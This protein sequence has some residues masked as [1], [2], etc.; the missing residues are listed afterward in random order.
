MHS[1]HCFSFLFT[2]HLF[3]DFVNE[4][5]RAKNTSDRKENSFLSFQLN[6]IHLNN[7]MVATIALQHGLCVECDH[8]I[9]LDQ[10]QCFSTYRLSSKAIRESN[11]FREEG[12]KRL[13]IA[14]PQRL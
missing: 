2:K 7:V 4:H 10:Q 9:D 11:I 3:K 12:K 14:I 5:T 13:Y 1:P 6:V 8:C